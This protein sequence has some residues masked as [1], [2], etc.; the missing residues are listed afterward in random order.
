VIP[1]P[2]TPAERFATI[3]LWLAQ[4]VAARSGA[5]LSFA[6][7]ALI[8][9]RL[10][11]IKQAFALVAAR[12]G[13]G[14]YRP[15][16]G[17]AA[18]RPGQKPPPPDKL[19]KNFAWLLPLVPDA[20]VYRG[21]IEQLLH[22]EATAALLAA[23]PASLRPPLRSLCWM[24]GISPPPVLAGP[25][26]PRKPREKPAPAAPETPPPPRPQPPAWMRGIRRRPWSPARI[27]GGPHPA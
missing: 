12:V 10:R 27:R 7:I 6:L 26:K 5:G 3:L 2:P 4:A 1:A 16:R 17:G 14:T 9:D 25:A 18:P 8:V 20:V 22:D 19:P 15:R 13:A 23:A 24:L 21:Q 11:R